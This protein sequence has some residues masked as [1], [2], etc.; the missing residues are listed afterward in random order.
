MSSTFCMSSPPLIW[1]VSTVRCA[2]CRPDV[3][4]DC[5]AARV[6]VLDDCHARLGEVVR[7]PPGGV[8][9]DVVVVRHLLAVQDFRLRDSRRPVLGEVQRGVLVGVL[10]VPEHLTAVPARTQPL[11]EPSSVVGRRVGVAQPRS[12]RDVVGR[13][14]HECIDGQPLALLEGEPTVVHGVEDLG[15]ARGRDDDRDGRV[16]LRG[17]SDHRRA[18]DVDLFDHLVGNPAARHR[19]AERIQVRHEQVERLDP[20]VGEL[21]HVRRLS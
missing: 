10:A 17:R 4:A 2:G 19:L 9:V 6:G 13:R 21:R 14:V 1:R 12:N 11:G 18:A 3:G 15:V 20:E 7:G 8:R 16:V 5:D